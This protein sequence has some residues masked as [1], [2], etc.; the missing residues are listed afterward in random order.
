MTTFVLRTFNP[1][2]R[3]S[4]L[5]SSLSRFYCFGG[6]GGHRGRGG[7]G[8]RC[9]RKGA[10]SL[11]GDGGVYCCRVVYGDVYVVVYRV[12]KGE[13][14]FLVVVW[15]YR[16]VGDGRVGRYIPLDCLRLLVR[17]DGLASF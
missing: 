1:T 5:G 11:G 9:R 16:R 2:T 3:L 4:S 14:V 7:G 13:L 12:G 8:R 6:D 15:G 17:L 10:R